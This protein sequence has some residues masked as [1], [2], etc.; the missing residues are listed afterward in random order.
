MGQT[1]KLRRMSIASTDEDH[2]QD[3]EEYQL[4][5]HIELGLGAVVAG[6]VALI[7]LFANSRLRQFPPEDMHPHVAA[8]MKASIKIGDRISTMAGATSALCGIA[9]LLF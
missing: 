6:S 9:F 4:L 7:S 5:L 2:P 3:H 1:G 8:Q